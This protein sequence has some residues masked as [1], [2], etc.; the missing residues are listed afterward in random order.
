MKKSSAGWHPAGV[1]FAAFGISLVILLAVVWGILHSFMGLSAGQA[2]VSDSSPD[3]AEEAFVYSP[4]QKEGITLLFICCKD[5]SD[6]PYAYTL[7]RFDPE[8]DRIVLVPIPP[9]TM[10]TVKARTKDFQ[11]HY[12]YAG[13]ANAKLAAESLLLSTV[14]RYVRIGKNGAVNLIDTLGGVTHRF[15]ESYETETVSVPAGTHL[16]NGE[17]LYGV[18]HSPPEGFS[19]VNWR[20]GFI[21]ELLTQRLDESADK[22]LDFLMETFWNNT[23]T[24]LTQFDYTTRQR[25]LTYFLKNPD[26]RVEVY[27]LSGQW[28]A[29]HQKFTPDEAA[30]AE[31]RRI[32]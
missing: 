8:K 10:V 18:M 21:G 11:N 9:E 3:Q 17:L 1:F 12:Q 15:E 2:V 31:L 23:D 16:L 25:A 24:D 7:C 5:R 30:L 28:D 14:D 32:F 13:C 4:T 20:M 26:K 22:S 6:P 29:A 19:P 27:P